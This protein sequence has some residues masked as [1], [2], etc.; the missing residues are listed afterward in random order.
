LGVKENSEKE[1]GDWKFCF[2]FRKKPGRHRER[3]KL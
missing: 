3:R 2:L 1:E